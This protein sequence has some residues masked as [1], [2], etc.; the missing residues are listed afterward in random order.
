[1]SGS[2]EIVDE[3]ILRTK[4]LP[5]VKTGPVYLPGELE[6]ILEEKRRREGI[7]L[8]DQLQSNLSELAV[9]YGVQQPDAVLIS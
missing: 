2:G 4:T 1:V 3:V 7:P 9:R 5:P 8:D 6:A